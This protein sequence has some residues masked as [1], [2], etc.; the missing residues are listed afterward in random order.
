MVVTFTVPFEGEVV[1]ASQLPTPEDNK[2]QRYLD[3]KGG[4][5]QKHLVVLRRLLA[6]RLRVGTLSI[7]PLLLPVLLL[8]LGVALV[9][10]LLRRTAWVSCK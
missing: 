2:Q 3:C 9:V 1:T 6:I 4:S 8:L 10:T 5:W 7:P